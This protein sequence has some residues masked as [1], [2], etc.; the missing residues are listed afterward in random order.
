[1]V[2]SSTVDGCFSVGLNIFISSLNLSPTEVNS[3]GY[4]SLNETICRHVYLLIY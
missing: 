3:P 4:F 2:S 1:M